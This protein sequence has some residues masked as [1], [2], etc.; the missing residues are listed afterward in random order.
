MAPL[1]DQ[2]RRLRDAATAI[3]ALRSAL[4]AGSPWPLAELYGT[5]AEASW[6]PHELLAHVDEMVPFWL[7]EVERI[8]DGDA[9]VP[10]PFGRIADDPIRISVIGRDRNVPLRELLSR[11]ESESRRVAARM[12]ELSD[13]DAAR[14]GLHPRVGE[15]AVGPLLERFVTSHLED[16]VAQLR[17]ITTGGR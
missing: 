6:G 13:A 17:E 10:V 9:A 7:G 1:D 5:E 15:I 14:V 12:A 2:A 3:L 8:L 11:L 16:H 4:E